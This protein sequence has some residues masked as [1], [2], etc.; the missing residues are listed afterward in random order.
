M[1]FKMWDLSS[2]STYIIRYVVGS[3]YSVPVAVNKV[4]WEKILDGK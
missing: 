2:P 3:N 4:V 1:F